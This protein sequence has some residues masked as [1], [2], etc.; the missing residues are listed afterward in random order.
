MH[1]PRIR[2]LRIEKKKM[3]SEIAALL[4]LSQQQYSLYECGTREIPVSY[5]IVLAGFY[6]VSTDYIL[7][8]TDKRT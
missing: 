2:E 7:G 5:L 4:Y 3:Q 6:E 1:F 8:L